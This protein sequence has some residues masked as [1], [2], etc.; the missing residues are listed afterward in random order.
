[1]IDYQIV[2]IWVEFFLM[3]GCAGA[4]G[5]VKVRRSWVERQAAQLKQLDR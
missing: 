5:S 2:Q 1:M 3:L 4:L